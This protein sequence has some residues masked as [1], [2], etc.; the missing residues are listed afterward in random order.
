MENNRLKSTTKTKLSEFNLEEIRGWIIDR[1]YQI[2]SKIDYVIS[3]HFKPEKK[4]AFEKIIL[5]SSIIS[6]GGKLKVLRN[7]TSF[8]PKIID[9]IQ[10]ISTIRNA[11]AHLPTTELINITI[12]EK[13]SEDTNSVRIDVTTQMEIMNSSGQLKT[14]KTTELIDEFFVLN[15]EIRKYLDSYNNM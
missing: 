5:N 14:K 13:K 10:K 11:F 4:E 15:T 3:E 12:T 9:K 6:F 1:M 7:V 2:E 8:D